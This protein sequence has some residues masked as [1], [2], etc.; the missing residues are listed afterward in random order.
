MANYS[1]TLRSL[2]FII[3]SVL[4]GFGSFAQDPDLLDKVKG[5][6]VGKLKV[7]GAELTL[8]FNVSANNKDSVTVTM[9]SPDQGAKDI[10]TSQV[11][12]SRDSLTVKVRSIMG[13]FH[14]AFNP[15]FTSLSGS[16]KQSGI[17]FPV[18]LV[19]QENKFTLN[20]PQEPKPPFPY[21]QEEVVIKNNK[22]GIELSGTLTKPQN[23]GPFPAVILVT[24]SG[25]QNRDEELMGHKPFLL[26]ADYLTRNGIAV[27]RYDDRGVG[28]SG[29]VFSTA[30]TRDFAD[31]ASALV[32]FLKSQADIDSAKIGLIGHSEGG[33]IAPMVAAQRPD[34]DFIV[35][36]AGPGL[37]G[38]KIILM[39]TALIAKA[40]GEDE[41]N[42]A[43]SLELDEQ[44]FKILRKYQD[45]QV[46]S[47]KIR[48]MMNDLN[49]KQSKANGEK[50]DG[51]A[52]I[53]AQVKTFTSPW[54]RYF[55]VTD[56]ISFLSSVK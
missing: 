18:E 28:K 3:V 9:D 1:L 40:N 53:E 55:L 20:R 50:E 34:V 52:E 37:T 45:N 7:G 11:K 46:A 6:W 31:D 5:A 13:V 25:P 16:W 47:E 23:S 8:V 21:L 29:G 36:M 49:K 51:E 24:G 33:I 48:K 4:A 27:L 42:I 39:Q 19:H 43:E 2:V 26:L 54:F 56:P 10:P 22:A 12:L 30:T 41:K 15:G 14:G 17:T 32:D 35:L 44:V 38:E